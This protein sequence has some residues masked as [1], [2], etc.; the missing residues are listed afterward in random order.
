MSQVSR[1]EATS[2]VEQLYQ[3]VL[4]READEEGLRN[5]VNFLVQTDAQ[6]GYAQ[7]LKNF[8][9]SEEYHVHTLNKYKSQVLQQVMA[10]QHNEKEKP[11]INHV[12]SLGDHCLTSAL[13][14][15]YHYKKYSLPFDWSYSNIDAIL[16]AIEDDFK[17]LLDPQY[18]EGVIRSNGE[19]AFHY[20]YEKELGVKPPMF[21]HLDITQEDNYQYTVR[22]VERFRKVLASD[23]S[24]LFLHIAEY[25]KDVA[26]IF[27]NTIEK[28]EKFTSNFTLIFIQLESPS[29]QSDV[30][31][32]TAKKI[33]GHSLYTYQPISQENGVEFPEVFD[34]LVLMRLL[35]QFDIQLKDI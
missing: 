32:L 11:I 31:Q 15:K 33:A 30:F 14:K 16:H 2:Y 20:F 29:Y 18:Y 35:S 10:E 5:H 12:I 6:V 17:I 26:G 9:E 22:T 3:L 1:Q 23:E 21:N 8:L 13:L 4:N 25:G 28:L 27:E 19:A 24:K 7:L 34:G